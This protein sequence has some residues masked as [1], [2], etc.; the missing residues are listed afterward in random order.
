MFK[1]NRLRQEKRHPISLKK[2]WWVVFGANHS[3]SGACCLLARVSR[4]LRAS[5]LYACGPYTY[6]LLLT[7]AKPGHMPLSDKGE[8]CADPIG[9]DSASPGSADFR[10]RP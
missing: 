2:A 5:T 3:P 7:A 10:S 1:P 8:K 9:R 6:E 4:K